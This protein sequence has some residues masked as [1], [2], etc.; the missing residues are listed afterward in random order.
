MVDAKEI[1]RAAQSHKRELIK[2]LREIVAI[3]S[4]SR[5]EE[6]VAK[7][8]AREMKRAGL[9]GVFIDELGSVMGRIGKGKTKIL[10]DAHIDTVDIGDRKKWSFDPYKGKYEKGFIYGRGACD[11]K[12]CVASMVY[13]GRLIKE[14]GL[15]GDYTLY[16]IASVREEIH[17]GLA[18]SHIIEKRRIRPDYVLIGEPSNLNIGY[19]HK[20]RIELKITA[21]GKAC[22]AATPQRGKN[23]IYDMAPI[24]SRIKRLNEGLKPK[25]PL[26]KGM[27]AVTRIETENTSLNTIPDDCAIY[28]DRRTTLGETKERVIEE[29][30]SILGGS[31]AKVEI[32]KHE[33]GD[34]KYYPGWIL[35]EDHPLILAGIETYKTLF[36]KRPKI[37]T[38]PF[39]TNGS[40]TM[41][42]KR[43]PT[44]GFGPGDPK[45]AHSVDERIE[46]DDLVPAT[47]F[48][49]LFPS[50]L[51]S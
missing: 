22:H 50:I 29:L 19:G 23:A 2:F 27:I 45:Y 48:Y 15:E 46:V 13:G 49:A 16:F 6:K 18:L 30:K 24:V 44:I 32:L 34:E 31:K 8:I 37:R 4:P 28:L 1:I 38:W 3:P 33:N 14:L 12:G 21:K 36:G 25:E 43:I 40:Y 17:E 35:D 41:G 39:C 7:R 26:G 51:S 9:N 10:Y 20:G 5:E 47:V 42:M 11:N